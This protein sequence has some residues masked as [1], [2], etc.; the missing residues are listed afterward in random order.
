MSYALS[1]SSLISHHLIDFLPHHLIDF[2]THYLIIFPGLVQ[3]ILDIPTN[4]PN[5]P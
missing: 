5:N 4:E 2:F 1:T 3:L